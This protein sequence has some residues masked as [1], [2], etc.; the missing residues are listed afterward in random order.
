[1]EKRVEGVTSSVLWNNQE[2]IWRAPFACCIAGI[3]QNLFIIDNHVSMSH[4]DKSDPSCDTS[5]LAI[6]P[7]TPSSRA[8]L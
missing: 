3:L 8:I 2:Q 4:P 5:V 1:V 7:S 6:R